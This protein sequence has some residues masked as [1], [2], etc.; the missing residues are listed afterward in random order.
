AELAAG[1][2][3][4]YVANRKILFEASA[5][6]LPVALEAE[7]VTQGELGRTT[8]HLEGMRAFLE[9]RKPDFRVGGGP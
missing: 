2:T 6:N 9:K 4:A 7:R 8:L 1:P 5:S 3:S